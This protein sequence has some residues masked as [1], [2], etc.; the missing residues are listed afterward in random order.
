MPRVAVVV[1]DTHLGTERADPDG[2]CAFL[3][4]LDDEADRL[5][6]ILNGDI[7]DLWRASDRDALR[8]SRGMLDAVTGLI[9]RG[10]VVDWVI[11]NHDHHLL[12][13]LGDPGSALARATPAGVRFH[14]PFRRLVHGERV[15]V[16]T[17]GDVCDF[18]YLPLEAS[19]PLSWALDPDDVFGFYEW[20]HSLDDELVA[21]FDREGTRGLL[22]AW[23]AGVWSSLWGMLAP[24]AERG[25]RRPVMTAASSAVAAR[26]AE[27][28]SQ[29]PAELVKGMARL[30]LHDVWERVGVALGWTELPMT[31]PHPTRVTRRRFRGYD[32]IVCGHFHEPRQHIGEDWAVTDGG[33]WWHGPGRGGTYVR[34]A[35]GLSTIERYVP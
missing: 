2:L 6:L 10:A 7:V 11:G 29:D 22:L 12:V 25:E 31:S 5:R 27:T 16:I 1:S 8:A 9:D 13:A 20:V 33:S 32:E 21:A 24:D 35:D 23:L 26:M 18:L 17:H 14:H 4:S 19:G 15:F 34:I 28:L 30:G 3:A